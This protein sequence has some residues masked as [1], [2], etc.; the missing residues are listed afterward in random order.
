MEN[1]EKCCVREKTVE[2]EIRDLDIDNHIKKR[3]LDKVDRLENKCRKQWDELFKCH[4]EIDK[5]KGAIV[6]QAKAIYAVALQ[7]SEKGW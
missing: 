5:L 4:C 3:I 6:E 7:L 1:M 2:E